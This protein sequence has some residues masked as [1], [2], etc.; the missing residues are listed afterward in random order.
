MRDV[1]RRLMALPGHLPVFLYFCGLLSLLLCVLRLLRPD[2]DMEHNY[3]AVA[4]IVMG[5]IEYHVANILESNFLQRP[6]A[7]FLLFTAFALIGPLVYLYVESVLY[8]QTYRSILWWH[9][10]FPLTIFTAETSFFLTFDHDQLLRILSD[11]NRD[12]LVHFLAIP[13]Y[14]ISAATIFYVF[15]SLQ[16]VRSV[17]RVNGM[18]T[19]QTR[20]LTAFL[21][22]FT[23]ITACLVC[24]F[25]FNWMPLL[26]SG[27]VLLG[28]ATV[29][30]FL[31]IARYRN[32]FLAM[33][34]DLTKRRSASHAR[35]ENYDFK[36]LG[37]R[38][39][40]LMVTEKLFQNMELDLYSLA[41]LLETKPYRLTEYLKVYRG[42]GFYE[43]LNRL[44]VEAAAKLLIEE[45]D[46]EILS[47][48]FE[49]GFNSKS[50]FNSIFRKYLN[51]TPS[52]YRKAKL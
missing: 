9:F 20:V 42:I 13:I 11:F 17:H 36:A 6:M 16:A 1:P 40:K 41:K 18:Y 51:Q 27:A 33:K 5:L 30:F 34:R 38:L 21:A 3:A 29:L 22:S 2:K 49:V 32:Y 24:G 37:N 46:Q 39:D 15:R 12:R 44:R 48:C 45:P 14:L 8:R 25:L 19:A 31:S 43:Y 7:I 10:A 47:I 50:S 23:T 4:A 52:N 26:N 28:T 35:V